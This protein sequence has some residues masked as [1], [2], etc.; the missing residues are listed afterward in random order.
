RRCYRGPCDSKKDVLKNYK[1]AICFENARYP[2][3]ITEK[4]FDCFAAGTVPIYYGAPN[5]QVYIPKTCFIDF[6]DFHNY[7]D[8]YQ[9]LVAM[10]E[11][12]YQCYL[13]AVKE[14]ITSPE[15]YEF[16]SKRFAEIVLEQVQALL[17]ESR[18]NRTAHGFKWALLKI[19][20]RHPIFFLKNLKRCR[21]F[22]F[23]LAMEW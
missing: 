2:G 12:E 8:L 4:I 11:D 14:F 20:L 19:V 9:F 3:L 17:N 15:Y 22:L 13:D 6:R 18:P 23:D 10:T 5:V 1:Y 21:R 7:E 16:T